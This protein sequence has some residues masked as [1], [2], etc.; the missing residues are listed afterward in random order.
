VTHTEIGD[1]LATQ[2][3]FTI[4]ATAFYGTLPATPT[5]ATA[6][7]EVG[8]LPARRD[9]RG[10]VF[11]QPA[12]QFIVRAGDYVSGRTAAQSIYDAL[13]TIVNMEIGGVR[14]YSAE[15]QPPS[16]LEYDEERHP[17]F[18]VEAAFQKEPS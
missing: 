17:I 5:N 3:C 18:S 16:L 2:G 10:V 9:F 13:M 7:R 6:I 14:Y 11:E 15:C 8:G 1:W 4:G 12:L